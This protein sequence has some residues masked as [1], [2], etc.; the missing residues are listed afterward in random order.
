MADRSDDGFSR[1]PSLHQSF[2]EAGDWF[3]EL[4]RTLAF[5]GEPFQSTSLSRPSFDR[6]IPR[7]GNLTDKQQIVAGVLLKYVNLGAGWRH[8][9][10]VL[11]DGV[12]RYYKIF[13][14][15]AIK[16]HMLLDSLR[17]K[18]EIFLVGAE[19]SMLENRD[20]RSS[21][22]GKQGSSSGR[23][24]PAQG[25]IHLQVA[26]VRESAADYRKFYIHTGMQ[27]V[28]LRAESTEDRW[29][30]SEAL[31][32][33][34][35]AWQGLTPSEAGALARDNEDRIL[36]GDD[37]FLQ[38]LSTVEDNLVSR[39]VDSAA[40]AYVA[41]LLVQEHQKLHQVLVAEANK[42]SS[43][44]KRIYQLENEKRELETAIVVEGRQTSDKRIS[45]S[46]SASVVSDGEEREEER[47]S[48]IFCADGGDGNE[49]DDEFFD[50]DDAQGTAGRHSRGNS[51]ASMLTP[52][53]S[54]LDG[55]DLEAE[56]SAKEP[57]STEAGALAP[58]P[59]QPASAAAAPA[60]WEQGTPGD[61][62]WLLAE[63]AKGIPR[64]RAS[65]PP[66]AQQEKTVSLWS[67][68]K[69][70]VGKDLSRV[71]LPV[72]FNEP[73]S[74]LQKSAEDLEYSELLDAAAGLPRASA[75]RLL[76][77]A[78]FA[79]S[80]YSGTVG[81]AAKPF[82]PLLGETYE[83][84][85]PEKGLR[86]VA[87][88]VVHHPT[89]LVMRA[90][91]R[92]WCLDADAEVR[93]KFWGR[94]IELRPEGVL[95]VRFA[96]G[97][98]YV[99]SKVTT[100]INNLVLGK[101]YVDHGGIM[102]VRGLD[103]GLTARVRF[104]ETGIFDRDPRQVR[105]VLERGD[106]RL[107]R[108]ILHGHWDSSLHADL[109]DGSQV[110]LWRKNPPAKEPTRYNLTAFSILLN[111]VVPGT[112]GLAAPTDCRRRPDQHCLELGEYDEAN[113][114]KQRLEHKQRAARKAAERG[115]PIRP[116]WFEHV[117]SAKPGEE[118]AYRYKGGYW[119][120]REAGTFEGCRDIFGPD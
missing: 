3:K 63:K 64:R 24:P 104:K 7:T 46:E 72:Y 86:L 26:G 12:L 102:R 68:I 58:A 57:G 85:L 21:A 59:A 74:A 84:V 65:L 114:E 15:A 110:L 33:A 34:K 42:R 70:M 97:D 48:H 119:E 109:E 90:E 118:P 35:G 56:V 111:E 91:G 8:R 54:L 19:V 27:T 116:R 16:I 1:M 43:L 108:P 45:P 66:P 47:V 81:R 29:V 6:P 92:A 94:S 17:A 95:R 99:W 23:L 62:A 5:S 31:R 79:V 107:D 75:D 88:K 82:N 22:G 115:D 77:V 55:L 40:R 20:R 25:E 106:E 52:T 11:E 28:A 37:V 39:N 10:F 67:L 93:S 73:L 49:T 117:P 50:V 60:R 80:G 18:G 105:G 100:S 2:R 41:D 71:C 101:I 112:E 36:S 83:L 69:G 32:A 53:G 9:L 61:P 96:D 87:E 38:Y 113:A 103:S 89:V 120:A 51:L 13:G 78:A 14:P 4:G 98:T 76:Y 44:L 30:W